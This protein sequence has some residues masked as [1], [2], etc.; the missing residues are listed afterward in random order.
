MPVL[1]K[2]GRLV[3]SNNSNIIKNVT[4]PR[5]GLTGEWLFN[6]NASDTSGNGYN[7]TVSGAT[8]TTDRN[9]RSN[10]AYLFNTGNYIDINVPYANVLSVSVWVYDTNNYGTISRVINFG[11]QGFDAFSPVQSRPLIYAGTSNYMYFNAKDV[12][13]EW[14]HFV[15]V[16]TGYN[17]S[18]ILTSKLYINS[19]LV[20]QFGGDNS[21]PY[22]GTNYTQFGTT[23]KGILDDIRFYNRQLD[24]HE[25]EL[26][27]NE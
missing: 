18:D 20:T 15:F 26:L 24:Q 2:G 1:S 3:S 7:G 11:Y 25:I 9:G 4:V 14:R 12:R 17:Q 8:L 5:N 13:N 27:Y 6:G 10:A 21:G 22:Q 16:L 23:F 19:K